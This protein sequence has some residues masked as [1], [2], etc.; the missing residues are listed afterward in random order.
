[1]L[2]LKADT[3]NALNYFVNLDFINTLKAALILKKIHNF[4]CRSNKLNHDAPFQSS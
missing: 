3:S 4:I 2:M 1:M